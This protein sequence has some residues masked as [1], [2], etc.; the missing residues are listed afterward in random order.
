MKTPHSITLEPERYRIHPFPIAEELFFV[1][2]RAVSLYLLHTPVG[3]VLMDAGFPQTVP[4]LIESLRELGF[5]VGNLRWILCTH[6]H[7][8]HIGGVRRLKELTGAL[9][10]LGEAD[11]DIPVNRPDLTEAELYGMKWD[12]GFVVDRCLHDGDR[13]SVGGLE[14]QAMHTPGHTPGTM[15]YFFN[16]SIGGRLWRCGLLGGPGL[17]T[18]EDSYLRRHGLPSHLRAD[19]WES[20]QRLRR[21]PVDIF[22]SP[23]P[24][25]SRLFE[26]Y[27]RA[28]HNPLAFVDPTAW[29]SY[30]DLL[31]GHFVRRFPGVIQRGRE[32]KHS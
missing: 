12:Q 29:P 3:D 32:G 31:E 11:A 4:L 14:I 1:G 20:L 26:R 9:I 19:Y 5:S 22:L 28:R 7:Y 8:D 17:A 16:V 24:S 25:Q 27:E 2:N 6:A 18:L 23:H 21:E 15:S 30:L 10:A 13:I